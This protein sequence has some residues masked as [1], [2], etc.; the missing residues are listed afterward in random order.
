MGIFSWSLRGVW[1][2]GVREMLIR[3]SLACWRVSQDV[4]IMFYKMLV[5]CYEGII[6]RLFMWLRWEGARWMKLTRE[7]LAACSPRRRGHIETRAPSLLSRLPIRHTCISRRSSFHMI[8]MKRADGEYRHVCG[9]LL[10]LLRYAVMACARILDKAAKRE[11]CS[12]AWI[13]G[14]G[15]MVGRCCYGIQLIMNI[16]AYE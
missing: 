4:C 12:V 5:I 9:L 3:E 15:A 2:K 13:M 14:D 7:S 1:G 6:W 8:S 16:R 10:T 11:D